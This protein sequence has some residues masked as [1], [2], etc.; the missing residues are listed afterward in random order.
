M[1]ALDGTVVVR[2]RRER[3]R[4]AREA[5]DERA[6]GE[7]QLT[8]R[9]AKQV[10]RHRLDA[11]DAATQIDAV[12][13]QLEDFFLGELRVDHQ[14]QHRFADLAAVG[15]LVRQEQRAG[16]LLRQRAAAFDRARLA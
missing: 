4:R 16:E 8:R 12:Q 11:V 9:L 1:A 5:G 3:G 6:L 15:L 2:P 13:V 10:P 14:R 7:R